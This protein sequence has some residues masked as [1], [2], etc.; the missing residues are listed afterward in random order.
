MKTL[1]ITFILFACVMVIGAIEDPCT[2]E[3]LAP[4]CTQTISNSQ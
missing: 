3:G 2:T 4:G 1:V